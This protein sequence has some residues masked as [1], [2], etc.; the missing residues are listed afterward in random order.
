MGGQ[1]DIGDML[2]RYK[3]MEYQQQLQREQ[4]Q[5]ERER[6]A[7][8][9]ALI[10]P[11]VGEMGART[12]LL[13][14]QTRGAK[15][16]RQQQERSSEEASQAGQASQWATM[17]QNPA[18]AGNPFVQGRA[19]TQL[20]GQGVI[21]LDMY[22]KDPSFLAAALNAF[23]QGKTTAATLEHAP[24]ALGPMA[25]RQGEVPYNPAT[26]QMGGQIPALPAQERFGAAPWGTYDIL[27]GRVK[28]YVPREFAE[29]MP[30]G[31]LMNFGSKIAEAPFFVPPEVQTKTWNVIGKYLQ[32]LNGQGTVPAAPTGKKRV[33]VVGPKGETGTIVEGDTLPP[34]WK[35]R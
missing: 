28:D 3:M 33:A 9:Q 1:N 11:Q 5:M 22:Q 12:G 15:S 13:T 8:Q 29:N 19:T 18:T 31:S 4:M 21:P 32:G 26:Q 34:G 25:F 24:Q 10:Q 14:E 17:L 23:I 27:S 7:M 30:W 16:L 6:L 35:T 2:V 20:A